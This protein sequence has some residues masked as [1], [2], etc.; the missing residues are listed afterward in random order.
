[1]NAAPSRRG[2]LR[3]HPNAETV[4]ARLVDATAVVLAGWLACVVRFASWVPLERYQFA[5]LMGALLTLVVFPACGVYHSWRGQRI[6][7]QIRALAVSWT[8]VA[9]LLATV[10]TLTKTG[11][12]FSRQWMGM[13]YVA[14]GT[15]LLVSR[16]GLMAV[17]RHLHK[18]GWNRRRIIIVGGGELGRE[19]ARRLSNAPWTGFD[20]AAFFAPDPGAGGGTPADPPTLPLADLAAYVEESAVDEVWFALPAGANHGIKE[21]LHQLRHCTANLRYV[22]DVEDF[23]LLNP[24][25]NEV[26]GMPVLDLNISPI[27]GVNRI[28]KAAE[29]IVLASLFLLLASPL[30]LVIAVGI[31]LSSP[32]PVIFKQ[33]RHGWNGQPIKI[34]KFRTMV[35]HTE[36]PGVVTQ[37]R[38]D[39]PRITRLGAF[40]RRTSL[41]EL[42]QFVNVLQGRMSV[43]GPRPH[44]IAHNQE[45][46]DLIDAYMQRHKVRPGITGWAQIN[47][48]RGETDC[49]EKMKKRI[50]LDL[51]YIEH[52]SLW[53]DLRII[54]LT[55]FRGLVHRNAY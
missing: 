28:V 9:V 41:D 20:V 19:T 30:M 33:R 55:P 21:I 5:L 34:Y 12:L 4:A 31:K 15:G 22:P 47:G 52:W 27:Q 36:A 2:L 51:Y 16:V 48:W 25:I 46:R 49:I 38:C 54:A 14:G 50:E 42:P 8:V 37:A 18:Q 11:A 24:A 10:G 39:D 40:L 29:D 6:R 26:A 32:G 3:E 35:Q 43:V 7:A 1:M 44:A 45:Y 53:F 17:L 13:W 23:R